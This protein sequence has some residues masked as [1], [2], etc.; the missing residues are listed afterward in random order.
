MPEYEALVRRAMAARSDSERLNAESRRIAALARALR[1]ADAGRGLLVRCAWCDRFKLDTEWL[2]LTAIGAGQQRI[3][4]SAREK[5]S[6]GICPDCL[7][8]ELSAT[9][10]A[11]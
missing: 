5:A 2:R 9:A 4:T 1:E 8:A 10:E 7:A 6:H 3:T 11:S